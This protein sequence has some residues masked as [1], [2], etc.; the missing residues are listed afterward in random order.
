MA[1]NA[2]VK[3]LK[4]KAGQRAAIVGAPS[5]YLRQFQPLPDG[6]E[7]SET[8]TGVFDWIQVF[9]RNQSELED[10][11]PR[12]VA[13]LKPA[14]LLWVSFPKGSSKIQT[15][16]TRDT[17]WDALQKA[18]LKWVNLISVD[19]IWSAFALRPYQP[20]EARQPW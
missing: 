20:G 12:V 16:L 15:D 4:L 11:T 9:V 3:K 2:L 18:D 8:L 14:S 5:D 13:A 19:S 17:G 1:E 6:T 7:V 10:A